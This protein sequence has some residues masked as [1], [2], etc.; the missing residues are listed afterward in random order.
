VT[1]NSHQVARYLLLPVAACAPAKQQASADS[2]RTDTTTRY[3]DSTTFDPDGYYVA[4][5]DVGDGGLRLE[6]FEV[7]TLER[8]YDSTLHEN[9][10]K[11]LTPR[12]WVVVRDVGRGSASRH[13]CQPEILR[14]D[15]LRLACDQ[16]PLGQIVIAV[17]LLDHRGRFWNLSDYDEQV[18]KIATGEFRIMRSGTASQG[19]R[20]S[21]Y[22]TSGH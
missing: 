2:A 3:G 19:Q 8:F 22:Y 9:R 21:F 15:S 12:A 17:E 4:M 20:A 7:E 6:H 11:V 1:H 10:P 16:T 18:R 13:E 5:D 14:R